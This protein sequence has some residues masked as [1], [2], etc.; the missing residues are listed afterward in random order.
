[1]CN[2]TMNYLLKVRDGETPDDGTFA[3]NGLIE[4]VGWGGDGATLKLS[5]K[6]GS[7]LAGGAKSKK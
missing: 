7:E 2:V 6:F 1:M 4:N 5:G 3:N